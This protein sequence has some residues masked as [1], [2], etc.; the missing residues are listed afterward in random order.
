MPTKARANSP[1]QQFPG[2]QGR[3]DGNQCQDE[4]WERSCLTLQLDR[5]S[6]LPPNPTPS[7]RAGLQNRFNHNFR[8]ELRRRK[9]QRGEHE[10]NNPTQ[11]PDLQIGHDQVENC[12]HSVPPMGSLPLAGKSRGIAEYQSA[13]LLSEHTHPHTPI[14]Q[15]HRHVRPGLCSNLL[16]FPASSWKRPACPGRSPRP[17]A[18]CGRADGPLPV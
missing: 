15:T 10:M 9:L 3:G 18:R 8:V 12:L 4:G 5:T 17:G 2:K 7:T 16:S 1:W 11:T 13:A 14:A 6:R